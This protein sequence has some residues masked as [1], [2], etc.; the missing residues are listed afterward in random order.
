M[1]HHSTALHRIG[2]ATAAMAIA[3]AACGLAVSPADAAPQRTASA[4]SALDDGNLMAG[5]ALGAHSFFVN[6]AGSPAEWVLAVSGRDHEISF[7][8]GSNP[9]QDYVDQ[10]LKGNGVFFKPAFITIEFHDYQGAVI[11][12]YNCIRPG[13]KRIDNPPGGDGRSN[14]LIT[15]SCE[16]VNREW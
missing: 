5:D 7:L 4:S 13:L 10:W 14:T 16:S 9:P 8:R 12:R 3:A 1:S 2:K 11:H 6:V 15:A